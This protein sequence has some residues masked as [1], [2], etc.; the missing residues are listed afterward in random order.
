MEGILEIRDFRES[1]SSRSINTASPNH[2]SWT[3]VGSR[4]RSQGAPPL[5]CG[6]RLS[7]VAAGHFGIDASKDSVQRIIQAGASDQSNISHRG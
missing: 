4:T 1:G 6:A 2:L 7:N 3:Y 5:M